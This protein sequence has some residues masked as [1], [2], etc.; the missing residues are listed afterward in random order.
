MYNLKISKLLLL[1][2][3]MI[4]QTIPNPYIYKP[5]KIRKREEIPK[6]HE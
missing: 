3:E 2:A 6:N 5:K 1:I 4:Q